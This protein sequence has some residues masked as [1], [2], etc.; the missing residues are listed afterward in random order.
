[1][2]K[3][4]NILFYSNL[5][6]NLTKIAQDAKIDSKILFKLNSCLS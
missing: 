1:M 2:Q 6:F 3:D 5:Y 4:N